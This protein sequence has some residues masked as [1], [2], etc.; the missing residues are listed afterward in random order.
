LNWSINR[1]PNWLVCSAA[2]AAGGLSIL[3]VS[4][5]PAMY[6]L[7]LLSSAPHKDFGRL[8]ALTFCAG[9]FGIFFVIPLRK[10]FIVRQKLTFPTPAATVRMQR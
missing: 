10:Y 3:A 9:F 2:T 4:A 1:E 8:I 6:R 7:D 5:I